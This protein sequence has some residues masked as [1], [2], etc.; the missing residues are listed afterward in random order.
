M[1]EFK[2]LPSKT[3]FNDF[4]RVKWDNK[5][6]MCSR[7]FI[8]GRC[9]SD[10]HNAVSHV[11]KEEVPAKKITAFKDYLKLCCSN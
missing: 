6:Q 8:M 7:W 3:W 1:P 11:Q 10:C 9:F 4:R 2:L 5:T